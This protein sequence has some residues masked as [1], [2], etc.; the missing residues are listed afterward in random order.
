MGYHYATAGTSASL[1]HVLGECCLA[2]GRRKARGCVLWR[3]LGDRVSRQWIPARAQRTPRSV[4]GV[5]FTDPGQSLRLEY[6]SRSLGIVVGRG[7]KPTWVCSRR[8]SNPRPRLERPLSLTGL[9]YGSA[10]ARTRGGHK[11]L[12]RLQFARHLLCEHVV[13]LFLHRIRVRA[14]EEIRVIHD[15]LLVE[16]LH[17]PED[18]GEAVHAH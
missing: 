4:S 14:D 18:G 8:D 17:E 2:A 13:L 6:Q 1:Q 9:D 16:C 7:S 5:L 12:I 10:A 3:G 15:D 11:A